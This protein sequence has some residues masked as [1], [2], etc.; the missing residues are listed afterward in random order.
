MKG[1]ADN[2]L[3]APV[4]KDDHRQPKGVVRIGRLRRHIKVG[5]VQGYSKKENEAV[6]K[7]FCQRKR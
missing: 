5:E 6:Q 1:D 2:S 7:T 4:E 3:G